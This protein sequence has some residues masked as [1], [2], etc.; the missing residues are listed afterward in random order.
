MPQSILKAK[1][2]VNVHFTNA[3]QG[4]AL[5][6][7]LLPVP[8]S[9]L[10]DFSNVFVSATATNFYDQCFPSGLVNLGFEAQ[11]CTLDCSLVFPTQS[12]I[13]EAS[14][15]TLLDKLFLSSVSPDSRFSTVESQ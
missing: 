14:T 10:T 13:L 11:N 12:D 2:P 7:G 6:V 9:Y 4:S 15:V 3:I 8:S 1:P 5:L